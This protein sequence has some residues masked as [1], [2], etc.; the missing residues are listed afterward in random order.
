MPLLILILSFFAPKEVYRSERLL[1][2]Q[3]APFSYV[4]TS[5]LQTETFGNVPCNGLV[6]THSEEAAVFDTPTND[7]ASVELIT[8]VEKQ[9]K[10][11]IKAVYA[12]HFHMDCLGGLGAFHERNIPSYAYIETAKLAKEN[13]YPLPV[14][15]FTKSVNST[16]G[17][18]KYKVEYFG[19]G[20][21]RDNVVA[22]F[23]LDEV[24]FGGC[25]IKESNATKG[26]LGDANVGAWT[27]TVDRVIHAY[28]KIKVVVPGHGEVGG[29]ELLQYTRELFK[30]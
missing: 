4:H 13:H 21:T 29:K 26:Y 10:A 12:T 30:P 8:W 23:P 2:T 5:Y 1:I 28:P 24:L 9:L 16:L 19:E 15:T 11:K 18:T 27:A 17:K 3:V 7:S 14:H 20:H 25:L 22:Y 6:I